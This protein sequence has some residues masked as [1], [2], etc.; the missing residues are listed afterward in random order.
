VTVVVVSRFDRTTG[1][2]DTGLTHDSHHEP[3]TVLFDSLVPPPMTVLSFDERGVDVVYEGTEF[4]LEKHLIEDAVG[5]E[6]PQVTDHDVL[7]IV[8]PDPSPSGEP[9]RIADILH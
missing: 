8:E 9:Q 2:V 3:D 6:Y 1:A 5:K 7:K 4:R